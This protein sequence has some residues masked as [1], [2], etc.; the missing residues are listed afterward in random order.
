MM[1]LELS[2]TIVIWPLVAMFYNLICFVT[3]TQDN[4]ATLYAHGNLYKPKLW[5]VLAPLANGKL[6]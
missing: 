1:T 2:F 5:K 4:K 6:G 3:D